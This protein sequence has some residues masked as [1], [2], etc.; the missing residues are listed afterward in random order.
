VTIRF[1]SGQTGPDQ[2]ITEDDGIGYHVDETVVN[3]GATA[4]W[5]VGIAVHDGG[6]DA[7]STGQTILSDTDE[8]IA[9]IPSTQPITG[10]ITATFDASPSSPSVGDQITFDAT[11]SS[12]STGLI[13]TY[14]WDFDGD[15]TI[16]ATTQN[17]TITH[18]YSKPGQ[19]DVELT[20]VGDEKH[21][22]TTYTIN[23]TRQD[24]STEPIITVTDDQAETSP[25]T[26]VRISYTVTNPT[27]EPTNLLVEYPALP[28]NTSLRGVTGDVSQNLSR[29]TPP[30]FITGTVSAG[31]TTTVTAIVGISN[32]A[33]A[34]TYPVTA[35]T[36]I[37]TDDDE[38]SSTATTANVSVNKQDYIVARFSG[39]DE[40]V[41]NLDVLRAVNAA[42][43]GRS[44]GGEPVTNL[45][46]LRLV[47]HVNQ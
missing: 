42:N 21:S 47:N 28:A 45:D 40:T 11:N 12:A 37:Q 2:W 23:I 20:V 9:E 7:Q 30:G 22:A 41:G 16:D 26:V 18:T 15:G 13:S 25:G 39:S 24:S 44:I 43:T 27:T 6:D 14:E 29:A 38:V 35:K 33:A 34:G 1:I 32:D 17:P 5:T 3:P 19:Y 4:S 10:S 8:R 31:E 46:V 36:T